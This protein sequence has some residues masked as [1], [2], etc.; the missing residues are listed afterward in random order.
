MTAF[1]GKHFVFLIGYI[2]ELGGAERQALI[3]AKMLR[4][5]VGA[6]VSFLGWSKTA[7]LFTDHVEAA[8]IP[9]HIHPL[10]W[11]HRLTWRRHW[12]AKA[13]RLAAFTRYTRTVVRP[14]FLLPYIGGNSRVA[15]LIWRRVGAKY[16]WWNQRDEG[17][18]ISGGR[19]DRWVLNNVPDVVSNSFA[20]RDF[21]VE[22]CGVRSERIRILHNAVPLPGPA[23]GSKWRERLGVVSLDK[24]MLM[25]ANLTRFKDHETLL[26]AFALL[27]AEAA[28]GRYH[29]ALAGRT[30]EQGKDL[31]A[32]AYDLGLGGRVHFLG[33][34]LDIE[35]LVAA[36]DL[37]VHSSRLEGCPNAVLEAMAHGKCVIGTDISGMR[38]ALGPARA[39]A[40]LSPERDHVALAELMG[41]YIL[42]DPARA[43]AGVENRARIASEF[44]PGGHLSS[45]LDGITR[46]GRRQ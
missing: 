37:I 7:G 25:T 12:A 19:L 14:D 17:R 3:L 43:A 39:E 27:P 31:K 45:V 8:G 40:F 42:N 32:L 4:D 23:D 16:T 26:R 5:E 20:G 11:D 9:I 13:Y 29:L 18:G 41:R 34:V 30:D 38:Q 33:E 28:S 6:R 10:D 15:G 36:S 22:K 1:E 2:G 35:K 46:L 21:L 24:L 44:S